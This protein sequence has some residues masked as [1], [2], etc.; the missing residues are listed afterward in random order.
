MDKR[1]AL[2][3]YFGYERFRQL[4]EDAIDAIL[5]GR[6]LFMVLPTGGGKSLCYQ[7]PALLLEGV[8]VVIS[9]LIALMHDQITALNDRG[10]EA[11]MLSSAQSDAEIDAV[12]AA[13][14]EGRLRMLYIAP[15]R[16][17]SSRFI[18]MLD[19]IAISF[20]VIDEAHCVSEWGHEFRED[21]RKLGIVK[22]RYG[23]IPVAAFTATATPRVVEDIIDALHLRDPLLLRGATYR[24]NLTL[25]VK[26]RQGNGY[27]QLLA[28][29]SRHS[30][31]SGIIYTFTRK[32][33]EKL[34]HYLSERGIRTRAYHAGLSAQL[35]SEAYSAFIN[36]EADVIVATIAFGM[37]IDK[38][39]I[40]FVIHTSLPKTLESYYQEVGRA[41]RDGLKSEALL[42]FNSGDEV[43]KRELIERL[44]DAR[45][46]V[47]AYAKLDAIYTFA[48]SSRCRH[49]MIGEYFGDKPFTCNEHCDNCLRGEGEQKEITRQ[50]LMVLSAVYR[51]E[52]RFGQNYIID[53]VRG[54]K[55]QKI[56]QNGHDRLSVYG[57]GGEY[58]KREFEAVVERL[59]DLRAIERGEHKTL[60]LTHK[61]LALLKSKE[62]I[63]IDAE[64]YI[65]ESAAPK[66][67]RKSETDD[68]S[69]EAFRAL[70]AEFAKEEQIPAYIVFSDKTLLELSRK[71]PQTVEETLAIGGIGEVKFAKYGEAFLALSR[72]L[73]EEHALA[74]SKTYL[75][76]LAL[77]QEERTLQEICATRSLQCSTILLHVKRLFTAKKIDAS[78][79]ERYKDEAKKL[80]DSKIIAWIEAGET[81]EEIASLRQKLALYEQLQS[82]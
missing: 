60:R 5:G 3:R 62:R 77:I 34:A 66:E 12:F 51:T 40:R 18:A 10:I 24:K 35:R 31:K 44:E 14:Q 59:F 45:Y 26:K 11:A 78:L 39:N 57:V 81:I 36:D 16:F 19:S 48:V 75:E 27:K 30:G 46:K 20:F 55:S 47:I 82:L 38:S 22:K 15:E 73:K 58:G 54:S 21:Y 6:D 17:S 49:G 28:F 52:Q 2:K 64:R 80:L 76:T 65:V 42:L 74:L 72:K 8:A 68:E 25:H 32:E 29:L 33:S 79:K 13:L 61:G 70:R 9:P 4:Q 53:L 37:G 23:D 71:L 63:T 50:A 56:A 41:G 69:F 67:V 43:Q 1:Q 7:L